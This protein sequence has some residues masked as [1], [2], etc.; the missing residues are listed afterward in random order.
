MN[1]SIGFAAV[2]LVVPMFDILTYIG[3]LPFIIKWIGKALAIISR[4]PKFE[5]F[6]AIEMMFLG[7]TE[8]LAVSTLQLKSMR[9]ERNLTLCT[10]VL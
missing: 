4:E 10:I 8:A 7:N 9:S 5:S 2:L 6:F 1:F 3:V